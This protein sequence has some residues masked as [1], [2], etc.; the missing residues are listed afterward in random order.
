MEVFTAHNN[1][2]PL[3]FSPLISFNFS[4]RYWSYCLSALSFPLQTT[5]SVFPAYSS[6]SSVGVYQTYLTRNFKWT[7]LNSFHGIRTYSV[8]PMATLKLLP[9]FTLPKQKF[10]LILFPNSVRTSQKITHFEH[11]TVHGR[12]Q[13]ASR[14]LWDSYMAHK[15]N[16]SSTCGGLLAL[17][18]TPQTANSVHER[19]KLLSCPGVE[20]ADELL[21]VTFM[22]TP[23]INDIKHFNFQL[24]HTTLKT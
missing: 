14:L 17:S 12:Y 8:N 6:N 15:C 10:G 2:S 5:L 7:W 18:Q 1:T 19:D 23:C 20:I 22:V 24:M 13:N 16:L 4:E 3:P 11:Q 21:I 9:L